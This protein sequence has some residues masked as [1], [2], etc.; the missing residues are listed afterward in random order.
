MNTGGRR[1]SVIIGGSVIA[2]SM[3]II[4]SIYASHGDRTQS[5]RWAIIVFI[6]VF[7]MAFSITWAIAVRLYASEIQPMRTRAAATSIGQSA[8][9]VREHIY[10]P[11]DTSQQEHSLPL[12][13]F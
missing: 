1:P 12:F 9:W 5:G 13:L 11:S 8:N 6:Y 3:L 2:S 4:G 7:V 10:P